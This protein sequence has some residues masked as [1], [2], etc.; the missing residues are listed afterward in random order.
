MTAPEDSARTPAAF[1]TFTYVEAGTSVAV[2]AVAVLLQYRDASLRSDG[3]EALEVFQRLD[4]P[5][6]LGVL[7]VWRDQAAAEEH[8]Q[9][10]PVQQ[11]D[12]QLSAL[13]AAPND[14]RLH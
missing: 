14:T 3:A 11:R 10:S 4:R 8:L 1:S 5:N 7:A 6:Q 2:K 13:L 12:E 9:S